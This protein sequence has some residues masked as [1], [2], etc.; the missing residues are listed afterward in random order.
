MQ[1]SDSMI[2]ALIGA[3]ATFVSAMFQLYVNARR[4]AAERK[5]GKPA[6]SK[7]GTWLSIFALMLAAAVGG[8]AAAEYKNS[9]EREADALI[10]QEMQTRLRDIG[11]AAVRLERGG[12]KKNEQADI[13]DK[14]AAERRRGAEGV[15]ALIS[16]P[17]C[18]GG[19]GAPETPAGCNEAGALRASVCA[20]IPAAATVTEVQYFSKTDDSAKPWPE[21]RVQIGQDAGGVKFVDALY[22]RPR[23]DAKEVC[24]RFIDWDSQKARQARILVKYTL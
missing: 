6:S 5:A 16:L 15:V 1:L 12:K 17:P 21:S 2:T 24:Q 8:Y 14:L 10:R 11:D 4:Q 18:A 7:S 19:P 3:T 22:E 13:D 23:A 9:R 20:T